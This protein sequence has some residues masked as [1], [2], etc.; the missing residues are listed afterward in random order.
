MTN[1][2]PLPD[3]RSEEADQEVLLRRITELDQSLEQALAAAED[4]QEEARL[5]AEE[6]IRMEEQLAAQQRQIADLRYRL[7]RTEA[8]ADGLREALGRAGHR[9]PTV[10]RDEAHLSEELQTSCEELQIL[11]EELARDNTALRSREE[12]L[13]FAQRCAGAGAWDWDVA[14]NRVT[15]SPEC[16]DLMGLE[17][18]RDLPSMDRLLAFLLP[19]DRAATQRMLDA[20]VAGADDEFRIEFRIRHPVRGVRWIAS[21]GR[22]AR[23]DPLGRPARIT[24]LA[25]DFTDRKA[26]E[27]ALHRAKEAA[28]TANRAKTRFL[29]AAS[30][31]LRQPIQA[32]ALYAH[33]LHSAVASDPEAVEVLDLLKVSIESLNGM[34]NGLLD[35]SRLEAGAADVTI[36]DFVPGDLMRRLCAEFRGMAEAA[37]ME[38][39][40]QP[41]TT[42]IATDPQLLERVLRNLL[43]NAIAHGASDGRGRVLLGCRRRGGMLAFQVWDNGPGI[44]P[45]E[46]RDT[47]FE[48]F[49]QLK[50]PERNAA[51]GCGLG[52][53]IVAYIARL[54]GLEINARSQVGRGSVFSMAVPLAR[55][56]EAVRLK[57]PVF[58][59]AM[60]AWLKGRTVLLVED[61]E[62]VRR[63]LTMMLKRWGVRVVAVGST[64][65]LAA[66][67]PRLR[68][69]PHAL[70]TDYRLPG[71]STGCTVV[72]LVR[73]R[74]DV[75]GVMITGDTAPE[76]LSEAKSLGCR[77]LHKPVEPADLAQALSEAMHA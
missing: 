48:E 69:R 39:R 62:R 11:T 1:E 55:T 21:L 18:W 25:L 54:L 33:A 41:T 44:L 37:G 17:S 26:M 35:L 45:P 76:R 42:P 61:D 8:V 3:R 60:V 68:T 30:H 31:D 22:V 16:D 27:E 15:W 36:V 70:V 43:S 10:R 23:R 57:A 46:A 64:E 50:N 63:S 40:C 12:Q 7:A 77:L 51:H 38:L 71:G 58:D 53:A 34:L 74:W 6:R 29:A 20:T 56:Q 13:R 65:E 2:V 67:L 9:L 5:L 14:A 72:E 28:E 59:A 49:R 32:A 19:E 47:I 66:K 75:P 24:G 4:A 73:G 52:L